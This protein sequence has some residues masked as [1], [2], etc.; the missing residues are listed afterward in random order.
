MLPGA[1][2]HT[3]NRSPRHFSPATIQRMREAQQRRWAKVRGHSVAGPKPKAKRIMSAAG[4]KAI[5]DAAKKRWAMQK[6]RGAS[7]SVGK[8][9]GRKGTATKKVA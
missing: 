7:K 8:K 3:G 6:A 4:R 1:P 9:A 2:R 5:S